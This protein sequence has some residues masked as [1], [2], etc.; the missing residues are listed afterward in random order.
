M[1]SEP[2]KNQVRYSTTN[3]TESSAVVVH[4]F[5]TMHIFDISVAIFTV[6]WCEFEAMH[7]STHAF[8]RRRV[9]NRPS[10]SRGRQRYAY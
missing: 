9:A 1:T 6:K 5:L 10:S 3:N 2:F 4:H 8:S 7:E